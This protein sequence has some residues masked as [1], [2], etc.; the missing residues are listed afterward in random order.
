VNIGSEKSGKRQ[1]KEEQRERLQYLAD[2][3][4]VASEEWGRRFLYK[5][6][7]GISRVESSSYTGNFDTYYNEGRRVVG[8]ILMQDFQDVAPNWYVLMIQDEISRKKFGGINNHVREEHVITEEDE[9]AGN[10]NE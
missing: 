10:T 5:I 3:K 1:R 2:L 6:I 9:N 8:Q 7:F 4:R